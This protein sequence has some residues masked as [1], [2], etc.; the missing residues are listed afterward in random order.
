MTFQA[1]L[2]C[3]DEKTARLTTQVLTDL[4][5]SVEACN[6]PFAAVKK[7]MGQ[8][9]DA[10]VV[11]CNNE[12]NAALLFKSARNS[13]SNQSSLAV[14][15]VEGQSGVANAFRIGANLVLT[16]PLN[17]EQAKGTLRV[18][19]GLLKKSGESAKPAPSAPSTAPQAPSPAPPQV[20]PEAPR[21]VA[22]PPSIPKPAPVQKAVTA[23]A[24][25]APASDP[26]DLF[27]IEPPA[28]QNAEIS[29]DALDEPAP[30]KNATSVPIS[31]ASSAPIGKD[32]SWPAGPA[33]SPQ[34]PPPKVTPAVADVRPALGISSLGSGGAASAPAPAKEL[35]RTLM[36]TLQAPS[37]EDKR[38]DFA[39]PASAPPPP[40]THAP[41]R[42]SAPTFA[43]LSSSEPGE[44]SGGWKVVLIVIIAGALV[45][46][47]YLG[48]S[49][50]H[51]RNSAPPAPVEQE[52]QPPAEVPSP[53]AAS[54]AQK[55][56]AEVTAAILPPSSPRK[57][58]TPVSEPEPEVV[59][60][61]IQPKPTVVKSGIRPA[62]KPQEADV[63][64]PEMPGAAAS[65]SSAISSIVSSATPTVPLAAAPE[66]LKVSQGVTQ[67]LLTRRV[68]PSYP[69]QALQM[70][71]SGSVQLQAVISKTGSIESVKVLSG[72][73]ILSRA[74][75]DAVK[76]WKYKPYML[77]NEP[78]EIQTQITVNFKLP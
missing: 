34:P 69:R 39:V 41:D 68:Q 37:R 25:P 72:D 2:F 27:E 36:D 71:I 26:A 21:Q 8:H 1:L 55:P 24:A 53:P 12:Q 31:N 23:S 9:F 11:D 7:L 74:A 16:K 59:V 47:G 64:A 14:A 44:R 33:S 17:V 52:V 67:G 42:Q 49:K 18:A 57:S 60:T 46:A 75:L 56:S 6:E 65:D 66:V 54:T 48:Y 13:N 20:V 15:V 77:D 40:R 45:A 62:A 51:K 63:Q 73:P 76:Q 5:F 61:Q 29:L 43:Q 30:P 22:P 4:D 28:S 38:A 35:P 78:V 32:R 10:I 3:Q 50:L 58:E 70:R 19:R